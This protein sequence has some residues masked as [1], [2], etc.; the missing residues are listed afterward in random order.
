[1]PAPKDIAA[2]IAGLPKD[3]QGRCQQL[4]TTIKKAA[5]QAE[6]VISYRLPAFKQ[7]G[8]LVWFAMHT[9]HIGFYPRASGIAAFKK[10]LSDYKSAK[11]S[12]QFPLGKPLPLRLVARM[13]KFRVR[14]NLSEAKAHKK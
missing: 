12:V 10:E 3:A 5:P 7:N 9:K 6:E 8:L 1:M 14:E 2:Y 4:R 11:G 13:V